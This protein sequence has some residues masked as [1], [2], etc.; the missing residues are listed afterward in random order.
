MKRGSGSAGG[1]KAGATLD[2]PSEEVFGSRTREEPIIGQ[3][4]GV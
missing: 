3:P 1:G 2:S 4:S